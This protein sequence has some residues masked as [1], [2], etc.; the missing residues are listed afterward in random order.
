MAKRPTAYAYA[1]D[2]Q[3]ALVS[4]QFTFHSDLPVTQRSRFGDNLWDWFNENNKRFKVVGRCKL[5]VD[6]S[7]VTAGV[8]RL[9]SKAKSVAKNRRRFIP[10]LPKAIVEDLRRA[11]YIISLF[12][13][14]VRGKRKCIKKPI[15]IVA[16]I[17]GCINFLS[18]IYLERLRNQAVSRS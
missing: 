1:L 6:W 3:R 4:G 5:R 9:T 11:F 7:A 16:E 15:T 17:A 10:Q 12:P 2:D 18:H 13:S 14:L 8:R